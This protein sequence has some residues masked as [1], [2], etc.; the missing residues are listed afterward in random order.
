VKAYHEKYDKTPDSMGALAADAY[1]MIISAMN[2]RID[3]Q[4]APTDKESYK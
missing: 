1:N 2:Q 3:S 4:K